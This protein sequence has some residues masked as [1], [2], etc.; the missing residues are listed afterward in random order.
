MNHANECSASRTCSQRISCI[1]GLAGGI[2]HELHNT[3]GAIRSNVKA[4]KLRQA[5][6]NAEHLDYLQQSINR[7]QDL[8]KTLTLYTRNAVVEIAPVN[9]RNVI[10]DALTHVSTDPQHARITFKWQGS[11]AGKLYA[12]TN[13]DLLREALE[14]ILQNA[15]EALDGAQQQI[16]IS[17]ANCD[18]GAC[19]TGPFMLGCLDQ[20]K[21]YICCEIED[22]G[23]GIALGDLPMIFDPFYTTKMRARGMG[24]ASVVGLI[25]QT[26][27]VLSC[28]STPGK[29]SC[30]ILCLPIAPASSSMASSVADKS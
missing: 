28:Q 25:L 4:L 1:A 8:A 19:L 13:H 22:S 18:E 12:L 29:G 5:K 6:S 21:T 15:C 7:I 24:L 30:F 16:C 2:I 11:C 10:E 3:L 14:A 9:V 23:K 26:N 27:A 20:T 17:V